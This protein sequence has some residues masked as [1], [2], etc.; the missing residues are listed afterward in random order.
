ML[1]LALNWLMLFQRCYLFF[2]PSFCSPPAAFWVPASGFYETGQS[3]DSF[4]TSFVDWRRRPGLS[5][6][7]SGIPTIRLIFFGQSLTLN[8][9]QRRHWR[10]ECARLRTLSAMSHLIIYDTEIALCKIAVRAE[11]VLQSCSPVVRFNISLLN[12]SV[13][14][15]IPFLITT[16][17]PIYCSL[18][19]S[20]LNKLLLDLMNFWWPFPCQCIVSTLVSLALGIRIF[21]L[22]CLF[23]EQY[24]DFNIDFFSQK[25]NLGLKCNERNI[26]YP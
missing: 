3:V 24:N 17:I 25:Y 22:K 4:Y 11:S 18:Q 23:F 9:K 26:H 15:F 2:C 21:L 1:I 12:F 6:E 16:R 7:K 20:P 8:V 5:S 10:R 13:Q 19:F 14:P